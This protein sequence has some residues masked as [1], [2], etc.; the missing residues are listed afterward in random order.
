MSYVVKY[1]A[2]RVRQWLYLGPPLDM[3]HNSE[4][5]HGAYRHTTLEE[6]QRRAA[7]FFDAKVLRLIPN[8]RKAAREAALAEAR[9]WVKAPEFPTKALLLAMRAWVEAEDGKGKKL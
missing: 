6:A 8:R 1:Y 3:A 4:T 5:Q 9:L 2:H 7:R